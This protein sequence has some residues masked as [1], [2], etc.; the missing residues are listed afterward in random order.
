M[1]SSTRQRTTTQRRGT[2]VC[3]IFHGDG[4]QKANGASSD[5]MAVERAECVADAMLRQLMS[6][7]EGGWR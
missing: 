1:P 5:E 3:T 6:G 2:S 7:K 4:E